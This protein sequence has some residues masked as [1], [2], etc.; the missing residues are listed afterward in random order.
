M[1][2]SFSQSSIDPIDRSSSLNSSSNK[3]STIYDDIFTKKNWSSEKIMLGVIALG[4]ILILVTLLLTRIFM[5]KNENKMR[6]R[7]NREAQET[8]SWRRS[9][10][11]TASSIQD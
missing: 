7:D 2:K 6:Y 10:H 3:K 9:I 5:K 8:D 4:V 1:Y 11:S